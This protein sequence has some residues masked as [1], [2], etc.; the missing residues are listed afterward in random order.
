MRGG[1][2]GSKSVFRILHMAECL[3]D[4]P[5]QCT[6]SKGRTESVAEHSWRTSLMAFL[7]KG[8]FPEL[9]MDNISMNAG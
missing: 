7:L 3:K 2:Y 5:R 9:D 6:T 4:T 1:C 8:K